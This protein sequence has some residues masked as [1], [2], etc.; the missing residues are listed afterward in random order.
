MNFHADDHA[1]DHPG[2]ARDRCQ[3]APRSGRALALLLVIVP[4][5]GLMGFL[6]GS[7]RTESAGPGAAQPAVSP[8]AATAPAAAPSETRAP[9]RRAAH[10]EAV[11]AASVVADPGVSRHPSGAAP[12]APGSARELGP[13]PGRWRDVMHRLQRGQDD[14]TRLSA[15]REL[16]DSEA[17]ASVQMRA[18]DVLAELDPAS[19]AGEL[20]RLAADAPGDPRDDAAVVM[21][22]QA[23]GRRVNAVSAC[24]LQLLF[25]TGSREVQLAATAALALRGD[26]SLSLRLQEERLGDLA[27]ADARVRVATVRELSRLGGSTSL[28]LPLLADDSGD[29]RLAVLN[30]VQRSGDPSA[31]AYIRPLMDDPSEPV[32]RSAAR[33]V[34]VMERRLERE[35][36]RGQAPGGLVPGLGL[37]GRR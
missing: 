20:Q 2:R 3:R 12:A 6:V 31:L 36:A 24:D 11:E 23:V 37:D 29:V 19:V 34:D 4:L 35:Q 13:D 15:A 32:R 9:S 25:E 7:S 22:I 16:M 10:E 18:L 27:H 26:E 28:L 21:A 8:S 17:P 1:G 30:A 33:M 5:A 14:A